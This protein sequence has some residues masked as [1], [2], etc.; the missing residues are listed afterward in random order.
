MACQLPAWW[1]SQELN[2]IHTLWLGKISV[3][4]YN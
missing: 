3:L 1:C 2:Y 4:Y